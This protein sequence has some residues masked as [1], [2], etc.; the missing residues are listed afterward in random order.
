MP[1]QT[2]NWECHKCGLLKD[3]YFG[4]CPACG[5]EDRTP[6]G[7]EPVV[8]ADSA[9]RV[10]LADID[11]PFGSMVTFMVKWAIATIP[12]MIILFLIGAVI[13]VVFS[14]LFGIGLAGLGHL[15]R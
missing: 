13:A 7:S 5:A 14:V 2:V 11:L 12:A 6:V 8:F 3:T 9:Q 15:A 1:H 10:T 4:I